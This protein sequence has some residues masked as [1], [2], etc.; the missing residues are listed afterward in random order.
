[1]TRNQWVVVGE[2]P[3]VWGQK[4]HGLNQ[5][6]FV[7]FI[8]SDWI[9]IKSYP[10]MSKN[11]LLVVFSCKHLEVFTPQEIAEMNHI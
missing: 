6:V 9:M 3:N 2:Q 10:P 8:D 4:R 1:V 7:L 11:Y 5:L